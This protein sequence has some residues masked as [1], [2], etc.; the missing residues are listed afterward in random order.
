MS[1]LGQVPAVEITLVR[2]NA[3]WAL[4]HQITG[5]ERLY[6]LVDNLFEIPPECHEVGLGLVM[7]P[8]EDSYPITFHMYRFNVFQLGTSWH[9]LPGAFA[10]IV[11]EYYCYP[12]LACWH[13]S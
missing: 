3:H 2:D 11:R 13:Y 1:S 6:S 9:R 8:D 5:G 10:G 4:E 12:N 7:E